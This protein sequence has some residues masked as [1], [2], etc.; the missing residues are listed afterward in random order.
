MDD[1]AFKPSR[2]HAELG[3]AFFDPVTPARFPQTILRY[4]NQA[5]AERVGLGGLSEAAW[6]AHFGRFEPLPGSFETPLALR[7][8]GHQFRSYNPELGDGRGFLFAQL[9]DLEDG[10]LLDLG[11]K[12]SGTTPWSRGA[13]GRL[14]LKG[15]V[16]E[17][18]ATALLEAQG[19][20][21]S[22][23]FSLIE[24][25]EDLVRG[26][27]PS[28]ARSSVLVRLSHG[29]IRIGSFQRV[30]ALGEPD[31]VARLLDHTIET[32][33]PDLWRAGLEDRGVA[34]LEDVVFRVARMGAQWAAAGF[35]HGVLNSDNINVTAKVSITGPGA[36]CRI[37]TGLHRGLF[38]RDRA[39]QLRPSARGPVLESRPARRLPADAGPPG[40]PRSRPFRLRPGPAGGLRR[41]PVPPPRPRRGAAAGDRPAGLGGLAVPRR[42]A[43]ALRAVLLR[44]VRGLASAGRAEAGPAAAQYRS[45][46]FTAVR[47]ALEPLAPAPGARLDHPYFAEA[48]CTLLIDEVEALWAPIAAAD[49]WSLFAAKLAGVARMAEAC[50]T[51]PASA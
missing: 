28:P 17:V 34:F 2:R 4:R 38:R 9:H 41:S 33:R 12:G 14:T 51:A 32:H 7:Y 23:S 26:D 36:S 45:E 48:P 8:H 44:L 25:G 30:L 40:A 31:N 18:L 29:H 24:T 49:D 46:A 50:G 15:G 16:R 6:I 10:R 22:K 35:V 39:L 21:T 43:G 19:V 1:T 37:S 3:P 11:T 47:A 13:D 27:E 42:D 5:W 20:Y